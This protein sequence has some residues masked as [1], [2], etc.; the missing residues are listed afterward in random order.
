MKL[1]RKISLGASFLEHSVRYAHFWNR[2]S[3]EW[4]KLYENKFI[5]ESAYHLNFALV[6][7]RTVTFQKLPFRF[8]SKEDNEFSSKLPFGVSPARFFCFHFRTKPA[9]AIA[10]GNLCASIIGATRHMIDPHAGTTNVALYLT[11]LSI[12]R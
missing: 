2:V 4:F 11:G 12:V 7:H 9:F 6:Y 3:S 10:F 1:G 8:A 5:I